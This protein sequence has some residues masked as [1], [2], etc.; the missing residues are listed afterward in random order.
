MHCRYEPPCPAFQFRKVLRN[1]LSRRPGIGKSLAVVVSDV[2]MLVTLRRGPTGPRWRPIREVPTQEERIVA[3]TVGSNL[4]LQAEGTDGLAFV[5]FGPKLSIIRE[6]VPEQHGAGPPLRRRPTTKV[7]D[8]TVALVQ[9][10]Q[11]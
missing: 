11:G 4:V 1:V 9:Q 7:A 6:V 8:A 3:L 10:A 2:V 5:G